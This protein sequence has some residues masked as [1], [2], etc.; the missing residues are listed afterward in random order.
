M[1]L[2]QEFLE[3]IFVVIDINSVRILVDF[4]VFNIVR[5]NPYFSSKGFIRRAI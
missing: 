3:R 5:D 4:L 2:M 1:G